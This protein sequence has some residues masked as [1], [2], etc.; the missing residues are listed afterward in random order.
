MFLRHLRHRRRRTPPVNSGPPAVTVFEG[1]N[2]RKEEEKPRVQPREVPQKA[3][4]E[5]KGV[6]PKLMLYALAGAG[7]DSA[8]RH[9][10]D[11]L[12]SQ[13]ECDDDPGSNARSRSRK[14][15]RSQKPVSR[16][17][18]KAAPVAAQPAETPD[19]EP[20]QPVATSKSR[21]AKKKAV[22]APLVIPGQLAL[23][24]T[25]QGAQVQIDGRSDPSYVTPFAVTNLQPGQHTITVS[26]AGYGTRYSDCRGDFGQ[27][28][29]HGC[30]FGAVDGDAG[31]EER[32]GGRQNF[33]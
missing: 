22:V 18:N 8:D 10:G 31:G 24:S 21:N 29:D 30:A 11:F 12:H 5:I 15:R 28:I 4:K 26:K 9:W 25:P 1:G 20:A 19:P 32:P 3:I 16:Q 23:D 27:P 14:R 17:P 33:C 6:P 2:S 7:S 13:S